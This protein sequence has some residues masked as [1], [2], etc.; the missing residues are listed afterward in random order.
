MKNL[1]VIALALCV[2]IVFAACNNT[3]KGAAI[4][5][6]GGAAVGGSHGRPITGAGASVAGNGAADD[7]AAD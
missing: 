1:K 3:Q 6:G 2:G 4:G 7:H 5:A